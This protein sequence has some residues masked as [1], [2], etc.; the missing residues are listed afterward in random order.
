MSKNFRV[1]FEIA[2]RRSS[3]LLLMISKTKSINLNRLR[4]RCY[5]GANGPLKKK[6]KKKNL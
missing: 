1:V 2:F 5:E 3:L 4:F 6:E